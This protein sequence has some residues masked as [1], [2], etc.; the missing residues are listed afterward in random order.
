LKELA[1]GTQ[2]SA[3]SD[4]PK[5]KATV[6]DTR[7]AVR[8]AAMQ[9][10]DR[11]GVSVAQERPERSGEPAGFG[12]GRESIHA[13]RGGES[14]AC[15][16]GEQIEG[17]RFTSC[18]GIRAISRKGWHGSSRGRRIAEGWR[19]ADWLANGSTFF[20]AAASRM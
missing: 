9:S 8:A 11:R 13:R 17:G 12:E 10:S 15:R 7:I 6:N 16:L 3:G 2:W 14:A 5:A 20:A 18:A 1:A 4:G 19:F